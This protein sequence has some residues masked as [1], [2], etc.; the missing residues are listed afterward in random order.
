MVM[1]SISLILMYLNFSESLY[2]VKLIAIFYVTGHASG[3]DLYVSGN[4]ED[5]PRCGK[6][7]ETPC[8]TL[9]GAISFAQENDVIY[10]DARQP[11]D[12]AE[13]CKNTPLLFNLSV[14]VKGIRGQ[15]FLGCDKTPH[16]ATLVYFGDATLDVINLTF[17]NL[18]IFNWLIWSNDTNLRFESCFLNDTALETYN[19]VMERPEHMLSK[20]SF[21]SI[22]STWMGRMDPQCNNTGSCNPSTVIRLKAIDLNMYY[23]NSTFLQVV[24][25]M[26][27]EKVY[28][29]VKENTI[30][31]Q[32]GQQSV[33][34]GIYLTISGG[35]KESIIDVS[36][37]IFEKQVSENPIESI[38]NLHKAALVINVRGPLKEISNVTAIVTRCVFHNNERGVTFVGAFNKLDV[39]DSS[40]KNNVAMHAGAGI[41]FFTTV[42]IHYFV[43]NCTFDSNAAGAFRPERLDDYKESF[44]VS[45]DEVRIHSQCCKGVISF[46]GKGG[47]IRIQRGGLNLTDCTFNNNTARLLGGA[48]FVDKEGRLEVN[49]TEFQNS[50]V[51]RLAQQGDILYSDGEVIVGG[52]KVILH[53]AKNHIAVVRHSGNHWS[54]EVRDVFLQCPIGYRLRVTNT[55]AYGVDRNGLKRSH[56]MDQ[57]SYFCESCPRNKYSMDYGYLNY[58][59]VYDTFAYF[60]L[61]INGTQPS[62]ACTGSYHH[63]DIE[64]LECPYGG[65]CQ[66]GITAVPNFWGYIDGPTVVFQH[67]PKGYCCTSTECKHFNTCAKH[68]TGKLCGQCKTNYSEALFSSQCVPDQFCNPTWLWPVAVGSGFLYFLFLLFQKD[69]RDMMFLQ[70]VSLSDLIP[71]R[72]RAVNHVELNHIGPDEQTSRTLNDPGGE[73]DRLAESEAEHDEPIENNNMKLGELETKTAAS[74]PADT[75]AGFLIIIF[76][77]FQDAQL[78]HVNTVFA[79]AESE[80]KVLIKTVLSGLFKFRVELFQFVDKICFIQGITPV[81]KQLMQVILVPYVLLQF[82]LMFVVYKW[83]MA[84]RV[85]PPEGETNKFLIRLAQGFVLALLFTY[86]KL[87]ATTFTL[88]KCVPIGNESV[89][90]IEGKIQCYQV[91]QYGVMAYTATCLT[92]FCLVLWLGPGLL[93]DGLIS[94]PQFFCATMFPLPFLTYWVGLRLW[95]KGQ[96]PSNPPELSQEAQ[97]VLG[98]LQG[99]FKNTESKLWGSTCGQG[100]LIARRLVLV[101]L[102]TF[103]NDPLIRMLCMMLV[104]F[105]VLL[106]H[107]HVLPF[108]DI[109]GNI[110]GTASASALLIVGGI[111]LMR[112]GFEAAEYIPQGPNDTLMNVL[113]EIENVLMLWFPA[114]VMCLVFISLTIKII[115]AIKSCTSSRSQT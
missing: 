73:T 84:L 82:G 65:R 76:F 13:F 17:V 20:T 53:T 39:S 97:G 63:H 86:Q 104:C 92:P 77:Y 38:M 30:S 14:T 70:G 90:F 102:H 9:E 34:G 25:Q 54:I 57:L 78:L 4:G 50:P 98:I 88:L 29:T 107:V 108:K 106:H 94:L 5:R 27:G 66:Q 55:S 22:N 6:S 42:P 48:I 23:Y 43:R 75:G 93:R 10:V 12:S 87:A 113:E 115:L 49:N 40:F 7:L 79:R 31:N 8:K 103:V 114:L 28:M 71:K 83:S 35:M 61:L 33:L 44:Q 11:L 81:W 21:S 19:Y 96:R 1:A 62:A 100:L 58:S 101:I 89:L 111:N 46:V 60:T 91:W 41:L 72:G 85:K 99:P 3:A 69:I 36:D 56:K 37:S 64:C 51:G 24:Q 67:C 52:V 74:P 112:A 18:H 59:L 109:R 26:K 95:L 110:A 68:R 47:A 105:I 15:P 32:D 80:V 2:N 16:Q 45:G